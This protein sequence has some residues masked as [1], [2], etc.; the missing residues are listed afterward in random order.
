[1]AVT[2]RVGINPRAT[3]QVTNAWMGILRCYLHTPLQLAN[4]TGSGQMRVCQ[5]VS[6]RLRSCMHKF[7]MPFKVTIYFF[8]RSIHR[9]HHG[10][11]GEWSDCDFKYE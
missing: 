4:T 6:G 9:A 11:F 10:D 1:M 5:N 7:M 2:K 8:L 3:S